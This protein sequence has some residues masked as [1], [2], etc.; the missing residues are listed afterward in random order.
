MIRAV[1]DANV[2]VA[3][4][5]SPRGVPAQLLATAR[6]SWR[7]VWSPPIV[8][9]C[10]RVL[11]YARIKRAMRLPNPH[12]FVDDVAALADMVR[13]DLPVLDV[14]RKDPSDNV[15]LA[16]ALAGAARWVVTGDKRHLL[17]IKT[18]GGVRIVL[19]SVFLAELRAQG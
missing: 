8:A 17:P 6:E 5:L 14:V 16:T 12:A 11:D 4:M 15:Y 18:F 19:P 7:L 2:V 13:T 3:A 10:H 1:L 9:E